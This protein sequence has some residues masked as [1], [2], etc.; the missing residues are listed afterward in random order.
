MD[1]FFH[2]NRFNAVISCRGMYDTCPLNCLNCLAP[3]SQTPLRLP[4][5]LLCAC[6]IIAFALLV[7]LALL[8]PPG[9]SPSLRLVEGVDWQNAP[10]IDL[11]C[12]TYGAAIQ[13][14]WQTFIPTYLVS[15][16]FR[17][18][19]HPEYRR[20]FNVRILAEKS[21][22]LAC[23]GMAKGEG[24]SLVCVVYTLVRGVHPQHE[25]HRDATKYV[26]PEQK[27]QCTS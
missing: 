3:P 19:G 17:E 23:E 4:P 5:R 14:F 7:T 20:L 15:S 6:F 24:G 22:E 12:R 8:R 26:G 2:R 10:R 13:I 11:V 27:A 16:M 21:S 18:E 1:S 25:H 9:A